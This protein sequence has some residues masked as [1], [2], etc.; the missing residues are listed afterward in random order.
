MKS[1]FRKLFTVLFPSA[2][3]RADLT[4]VAGDLGAQ[5]KALRARLDM[6]AST[7]G[8]MHEANE[9]STMT[10]SGRIAA[11]EAGLATTIRRLNSIDAVQGQIETRV[12]E[13]LPLAPNGRA[14]R[15]EIV[16]IK[17]PKGRGPKG[18]AK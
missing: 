11:L 7:Q 3:T 2:I 16:E 9:I 13:P 10:A 5:I 1:L 4:I 17:Q 12:F 18:G 8:M 14:T 15:T 6:V